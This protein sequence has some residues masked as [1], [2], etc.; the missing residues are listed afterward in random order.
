MSCFVQVLGNMKGIVAAAVSVAIFKNPVSMQSAAGYFVT[1]CG[2]L[3]YS[4]V[5]KRSKLQEV[6]EK[7]NHPCPTEADNWSDNDPLLP[8]NKKVGQA[9]N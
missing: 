8:I 2:V 9:T 6:P 7:P 1:I 5:K 4:E 3:A